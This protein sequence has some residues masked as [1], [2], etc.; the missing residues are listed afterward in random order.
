MLV[1]LPNSRSGAGC[2][3]APCLVHGR[4]D[5]PVMR[6]EVWHAVAMDRVGDV[7]RQ[8][9]RD[10]GHRDR[11]RQHAGRGAASDREVLRRQQ[12]RRQHRPQRHG[13]ERREPHVQ[14][15]RREDRREQRHAGDDHQH[16][17][18]R[19]TRRQHGNA[20]PGCPSRSTPYSDH[21]AQQAISSRAAARSTTA[22]DRRARLRS[23]SNG[24]S[25][26]LMPP[27]QLHVV[28]F[29]LRDHVQ[30]PAPGLA[31]HAPTYSPIIPSTRN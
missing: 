24:R 21:T 15:E 29:R 30:R 6:G 17:A 1:V 8:Q 22:P 9:D 4:R 2:R 18:V 19:F 5:Q 11:R 25:S 12:R 16:A 23:R 7:R 27:L 14:R 28:R 10:T 20:R 13:P 3:I 31:Q 26:L